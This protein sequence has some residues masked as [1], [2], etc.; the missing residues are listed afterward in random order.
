VGVRAGSYTALSEAAILA[1]VDVTIISP[2][3][4][5]IRPMLFRSDDARI[6]GRTA[7]RQTSEAPSVRRRDYVAK[8]LSSAAGDIRAHAEHAQSLN[9]PSAAAF[10][11]RPPLG[12][13]L[14]PQ[15]SPG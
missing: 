11:A 1:F 10:V 2:G 13:G 4:A 14:I 7:E 8:A 12:T 15:D 5:A 9:R 6:S 3:S